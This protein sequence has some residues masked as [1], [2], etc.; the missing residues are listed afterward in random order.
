MPA[1]FADVQKVWYA[2]LFWLVKDLEI[3]IR[4][5]QKLVFTVEPAATREHPGCKAIRSQTCYS[6]SEERDKRLGTEQ[7]VSW[8]K[9][10]SHWKSVHLRGFLTRH[11]QKYHYFLHTLLQNDLL[12]FSLLMRHCNFTAFW[13]QHT[14]HSFLFLP[15]ALKS[16]LLWR[17]MET[18]ES[19]TIF[20]TALWMVSRLGLHE[21]QR[22]VKRSCDIELERDEPRV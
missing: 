4:C 2:D 6:K 10:F 17:S 3:T 13:S 5:T 14:N 19:Q 16:S 15:R 7:A 9:H 12:K 11:E 21:I 18:E 22:E 20:I 8:Q 1:C